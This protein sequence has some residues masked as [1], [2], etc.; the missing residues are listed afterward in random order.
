[1]RIK[2][3][4]VFTDTCKQEHGIEL[5]HLSVDPIQT[6]CSKLVYLVRSELSLMRFISSHVHN[7]T[8]KGLQRE[9]Y[10]YF[11]PR[12]SVA[13]EKV[14]MPSLLQMYFLGISYRFRWM[15]G[16]CI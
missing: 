8:S 6:D 10:V 2:I 15:Q 7:D 14:S 5:R 9:Y 12:R 16:A 11:V 3:V 13:C 4:I 1:M